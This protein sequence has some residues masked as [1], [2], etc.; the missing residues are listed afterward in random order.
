MKAVVQEGF[1]DGSCEWVVVVSGELFPDALNEPID[2]DAGWDS[3]KSNIEGSPLSDKVGVGLRVVIS[4][5][6]FDLAGAGA[7]GG[8]KAEGG[9]AE[10]K[11][12]S[13]TDMTA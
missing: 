6:E 4:I 11:E 5:L 13:R 10:C 3:V 9:L 7:E 12:L 8:A 2:F 1:A